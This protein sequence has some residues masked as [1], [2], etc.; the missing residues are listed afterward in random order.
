LGSSLALGVRIVDKPIQQPPYVFGDRGDDYILLPINPILNTTELIF[1]FGCKHLSRIDGRLD[2]HKIKEM[3]FSSDSFSRVLRLFI[4][5]R[6][7][8]RK[9]LSQ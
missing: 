9:T 5:G 3:L 7:R 6:R 2:S 8:I 1:Q 4:D